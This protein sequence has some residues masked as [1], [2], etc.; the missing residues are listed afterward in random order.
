MKELTT[1]QSRYLRERLSL[2]NGLHP[3]I[4]QLTPPLDRL[5]CKLR[6][7]LRDA[8]AVQRTYVIRAV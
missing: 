5:D 4:L 1:S 3:R 8:H 6:A 7:L 2:K